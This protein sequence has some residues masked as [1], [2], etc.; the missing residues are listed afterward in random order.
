MRPAVVM[1]LDVNG[2][3]IVRSLSRAGMANRAWSEKHAG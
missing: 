2:Y 1:G 3:G